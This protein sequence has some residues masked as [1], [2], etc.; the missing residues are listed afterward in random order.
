YSVGVVLYEMV[1]GTVPFTGETA[2][3]IAMKHLSAVPEPPS[4]R[5]PPGRGD[6]P[7][8]L[9]LVVLRA[10]SKDPRDRYQ[11]AREMDADLA[12]VAQGLPVA[13]ETETAATVL[14]TGGAVD[15]TQVLPRAR[16]TG[17]ATAP[18]A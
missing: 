5:R 1:T 4:Q 3:E 11:S 17:G 7:N 15:S 16:R 9:D 14:L 10:L 2:L 12:R 8:E 13:A 6:I 18:T